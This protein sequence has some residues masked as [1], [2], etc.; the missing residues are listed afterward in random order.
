MIVTDISKR[1]NNSN[2]PIRLA[3]YC[4]VSTSSDDQIHSFIAQ[5]KHYREFERDHPEY[6]LVKVY[7]D[8]G[9]T[10]T[11][12][13][14]RENFKCMIQDCRDGKIDRIV[15][16]SVSRF[17]RNNEECLTVLRELREIGVS[18]FFEKENL[19]TGVMNSE[20]MIALFGM[21]AQQES[22]SIS[23]NMRWSYQHRMKSGEFNTCKPALGFNLVNG[24]LRIVEEEAQI[25]RRIYDMFLSGMGKAAIAKKLNEEGVG[26]KMGFSK[27][28]VYPIHYILTNER[29]MG[30]ALLQK[31]YTTSTLPFREKFNHGEKEQYYVEN[32]NDA[33]ISKDTFQAVQNLIALR[34]E[35]NPIQNKDQNPFQG[36]LLCS[37]CGKAMRRIRR[38]REPKWVCQGY[39]KQNGDCAAH[40]VYE[41]DIERAFVNLVNKLKDNQK[42]IIDETITLLAKAIEI[43]GGNQERIHELNA[44]I[45]DLCKRK[46][47]VAI[48]YE[49]NILN[50]HDFTVKSR[51][52]DAELY[53]MRCERRKL[54]AQDKQIES[55]DEL[56]DLKK[57]IEKYQRQDDFDAEL[58]DEVVHSIEVT[59][60]GA[61]SFHILGGLKL[62][63]RSSR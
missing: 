54:L 51:D 13:E 35:G 12:M 62:K 47:Q 3:A 42:E 50:D 4:R 15:V 61:L 57:S 45:A 34:R 26:K 60:D 38:A 29:Y 46:H 25:V 36:I 44:I 19:D 59:E 16:K 28:H 41:K 32:S 39:S 1:E 22:I 24:K 27:W 2:K 17:S 49:K 10:G 20:F 48:L 6:Q 63:E 30:D 56:N 11:S 9:I 18:V 8:E 7:A 53:S 40:T 33:I 23:E 52:I 43:S 5:V 37:T 21:N 58:F 55:L 31:R 14:K